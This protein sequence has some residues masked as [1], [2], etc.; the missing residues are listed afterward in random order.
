MRRWNGRYVVGGLA[1]FAGTKR[2]PEGGAQVMSSE[3]QQGMRYATWGS[4][5][6]EPNSEL[7]V[8]V[9]LPVLLAADRTGA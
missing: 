9:V 6:G 1:V 4:R 7:V 8:K 2:A 5:R 3:P